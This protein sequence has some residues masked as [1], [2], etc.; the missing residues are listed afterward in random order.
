MARVQRY[1]V[2]G[3][4]VTFVEAPRSAE[5]IREIP[6]R[7]SVP[8]IVNVVVGGKTPV[9]G[10]EELAAMG[11][12]LVLYANAALQG[13]IA[14]MMAALTQLKAA[15]KMDVANPA[16]ASFAERQRLVRKPL[17]DALEKKYGGEK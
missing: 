13:A 16:L 9:L 15:G 10:Q 5:E 6:K 14:G 2:E 17:F 7:L 4:D 1:I 11:Y 8:Q 3:A 12:G